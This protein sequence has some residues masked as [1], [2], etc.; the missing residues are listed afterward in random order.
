MATKPN[1][2]D[3]QSQPGARG[4][5]PTF[6]GILSKS[7]PHAQAEADNQTDIPHPF[8][9]NVPTLKKAPPMPKFVPRPQVNSQR[10]G[11]VFSSTPNRDQMKLSPAPP[12]KD[13]HRKLM[14]NYQEVRDNIL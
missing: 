3:P 11:Q 10:G 1:P 7:P 8:S 2:D 9:K 6:L 4:M 5:V 12:G 13:E 14:N